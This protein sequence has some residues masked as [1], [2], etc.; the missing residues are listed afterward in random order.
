MI[1]IGL[2]VGTSGVRGVAL[3]LDGE[4]L[5]VAALPL[6]EPRRRDTRV[7]QDP[8]LW[9][10]AL[11]R[12]IS[13]LLSQVDAGQV[14]AISV[15]ATSGTVLLAREDGT[16]LTPALMYNDGRALEE[17]ARIAGLAPRECAAHGVTSSLAKAMWLLAQTPRTPLPKVLH[18]GD[19]LIGELTGEHCHSDE[20]TC[21]KLGYDPVQRCWPGWLFQLG[22]R[23]QQLPQVHRPGDIIAPL[24]A[25]LAAEW[26]VPPSVAVLAGTTD[27]T[28]GFLATGADGIGDAVTS[29]GSTLVLKVLS[30]H[31]VFAPEYGVYSQPLGN[32]WLVGGGSN[33]GGAVLRQLFTPEQIQDLTAR[34]DP[35][36]FTGLDYYPLPGPGERFP[37]NDPQMPPRLIP[38]PND[39]AVFFQGILEAMARIER[40]GYER[41]AALGAPYPRRVMSIGGGAANL[42]WTRIRGQMLGVP[43]DAPLHQEA[44]YG[45]VRLTIPYLR[46]QVSASTKAP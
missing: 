8:V 20:N 30:E 38:R 34:L 44:A 2:D 24:R 42:A 7:E 3:N 23:P 45:A 11:F 22:L 18:Q 5:A 16:P 28:A 9:R 6:P 25:T 36:R 43:M 46:A 26:N 15:D 19:W 12:V 4:T 29:L 10:D 40:R 37:E 32:R 39:D 13:A 14:A 41:L 31:P 35:S 21:L 27:S 33:T 17:T 1:G